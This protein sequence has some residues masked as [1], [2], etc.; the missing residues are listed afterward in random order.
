MNK[1]EY[2]RDECKRGR[3]CVVKFIHLPSGTAQA[4]LSTRKIIKEINNQISFD[5]VGCVCCLLG[6]VCRPVALLFSSVRARCTHTP[7]T[8][9][10]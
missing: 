6:R 7:C 5:S 10:V 9:R 3:G 4:L 8:T 2:L 1:M